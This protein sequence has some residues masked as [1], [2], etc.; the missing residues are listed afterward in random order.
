MRRRP[1]RYIALLF[2][3]FARAIVR[4]F[5]NNQEVV[6]AKVTV[7]FQKKGQADAFIS[8]RAKKQDIV[9]AN[10][11][12]VIN[13]AVQLPYLAEGTNPFALALKP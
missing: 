10:V 3:V 6:N 8:E 11:G 5:F 9:A 12:G 2:K 7:V 1:E 13:D 4:V